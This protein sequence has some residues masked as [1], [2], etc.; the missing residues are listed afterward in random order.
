MTHV[1]DTHSLVWFLEADPRLSPAARTA[2]SDPTIQ[3]IIPAMV[4]VEI[5]FLYSRHRIA[6][7]LT[8]A[9]ARISS[10]PNCKIH[11]LDE[12]VAQHIP[13]SLNIHDAIIVAT[14]LVYRDLL[15]ENTSVITKDAQIIASGL[16][17]VI[18]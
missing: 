13:T 15:G 1:V 18:W 7:N 11:P 10:T 9:L 17:Q 16:I 3:V 6:L 12:T 4:L 2:L 14:A 8:A 5:L